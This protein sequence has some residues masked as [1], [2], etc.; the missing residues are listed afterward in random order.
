MLRGHKVS[1]HVVV[2]STATIS[3]NSGNASETQITQFSNISPL[4][5]ICKTLKLD[6]VQISLAESL[7]AITMSIT[8][9]QPL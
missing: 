2:A 1:G 7:A 6:K 4:Q 8:S 3:I 5:P 9:T